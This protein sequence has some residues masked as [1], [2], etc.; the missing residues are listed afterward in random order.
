MAASYASYL[1]QMERWKDG[2][3]NLKSCL[4]DSD[5]DAVRDLS[6]CLDRGNQLKK[7]NPLEPCPVA[8]QIVPLTVTSSWKAR[9]AKCWNSNNLRCNHCLWMQDIGVNAPFRTPL[10]VTGRESDFLSCKYTELIVVYME[11]WRATASW[12]EYLTCL[13]VKEGDW[14]GQWRQ[15]SC[16][17]REG[18]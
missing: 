5:S 17:C 10:G 11:G 8:Q 6:Q 9:Y 7:V 15:R 12:L 16:A 4:K 1:P 2:K 18:R 14:Q 13:P 3:M